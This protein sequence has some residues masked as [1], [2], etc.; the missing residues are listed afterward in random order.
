MPSVTDVTVLYGSYQKARTRTVTKSAKVNKYLV[1]WD[2]NMDMHDLVMDANPA[3]T[4]DLYR[5]Q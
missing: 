1:R 4:D 5:W 2:F 3:L